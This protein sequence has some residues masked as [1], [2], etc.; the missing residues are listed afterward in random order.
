MC[1][2]L[3]F[4]PAT[5]CRD[6]GHLVWNR[7]LL[8]ALNPPVK[9]ATLRGCRQIH[10]SVIPAETTGVRESGKD[11]RRRREDENNKMIQSIEAEPRRKMIK[12]GS[13]VEQ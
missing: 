5:S 2:E 3:F 7:E 8:S 12:T 6:V 11:P 10:A 9:P 1:S 4:F 13:S